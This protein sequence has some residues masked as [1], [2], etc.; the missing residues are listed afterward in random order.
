MGGLSK[1]TAR[2]H[3]LT[4]SRA[5]EYTS[6]RLSAD[7][8]MMARSSTSSGSSS[9][10]SHLYFVGSC[11]TRIAGYLLRI[12][13][14]FSGG[15]FSA[16]RC[17]TKKVVSVDSLRKHLFAFTFKMIIIF[18]CTSE[19]DGGLIFSLF[20]PQNSRSFEATTAVLVHSF[21]ATTAVLVHSCARI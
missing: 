14:R 19:A 4:G 15:S 5:H 18:V 6:L 11:G 1:A 12:G 2:S 10:W 16:V 17:I 8:C 13:H 7:P 3:A 20:A 21:E 9:S